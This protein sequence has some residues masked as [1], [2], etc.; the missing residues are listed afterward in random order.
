MPRIA[1]QPQLAVPTAIT[2]AALL[3]GP[4]TRIS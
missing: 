4:S 2:G 3:S 1:T